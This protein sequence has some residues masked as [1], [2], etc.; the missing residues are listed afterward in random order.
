MS[1]ETL[2]SE[3][4]AA[5]R[6][7]MSPTLLRWFTKNAPKSG[8]PRKLKIAKEENGVIF[9]D[10]QQ[11]LSFN[12]W[13]RQPW[14]HQPGKRPNIPAGIR[15]EIKTEANGA[16]ALCQSH[17][18]SCEI[19]HLDPVAKTECNH[20]EGLL[21]LCANHHTKY[22]NGRYGP[23]KENAE[24]VKSLK[25]VLHLHK[26]RLWAMQ[27]EV[28]RK[29]FLILAE[30]ERLDEELKRAKTPV[31][32]KA[33]ESIAKASLAELPKLAPVSH[34]DPH[35]AAYKAISA[36]L[37]AVSTKTAIPVQLRQAKRIKQEYVAALGYVA[38][39]LCK[40]SG[41][42]DGADCLVC[43]GDREIA[44]EAADQVDLAEFTKVECPLCKG[45]GKFDGEDC[46]EC[47]GEG[48]MQRR[49]AENVDTRQYKR[50]ECPLCKGGG[51]Y[52]G[53]DCPGC[54]GDGEMP[55]YAADQVDVRQYKSVECPLCKGKG[56]YDADRCP[57]C[58]GDGEMPGYAADQ[59][60][61]RQY[62]KVKCPLC[63]GSGQFDG[64]DCPE[65]QA[66][67][68][69]PRGQA[70]NVD[71]TRYKKVACPLCE[72]RHDA[73]RFCDGEGKVYKGAADNF[74]SG[75]YR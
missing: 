68:E 51:Q 72:G 35:Y 33:I 24:F 54:H 40:A 42:Y 36:D 46:P 59:V 23:D 74:D 50:V 26:R 56:V 32:T 28:G 67:G 9:F 39:P 58:G 1:Q 44:E 38:C 15:T 55:R 48:N 69:T 57:E 41:Y 65:C 21:N 43:G 37:K 29:L 3:Y 17:G 18:D 25:T 2:L 66:E 62:K 30:C 6:V 10:E 34:A 31:Q 13:L 8:D 7:G 61:V 60:D 73:C 63:M 49:F 20:P 14:P 5:T 19:A 45:G 4:E 64:D 71:L 27:D 75:D 11:L 22:D 12:D 47:G 52:D 70:E 53:D 16:C